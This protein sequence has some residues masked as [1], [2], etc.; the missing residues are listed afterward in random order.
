MSDEA[1]CLVRY[2]LGIDV[3]GGIDVPRAGDPVPALNRRYVVE[4]ITRSK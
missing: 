1:Y 3:E 4:Y 2:Q